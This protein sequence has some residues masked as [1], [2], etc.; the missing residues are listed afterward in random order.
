[1]L[2]RATGGVSLDE[3]GE[4]EFIAVEAVDA[5]VDMDLTGK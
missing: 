2:W 4:Q 3:L 1:M 5:E